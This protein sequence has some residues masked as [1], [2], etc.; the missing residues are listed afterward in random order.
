MS[1]EKEDRWREGSWGVLA[2][3]GIALGLVF[4]LL[5]L[6]AFPFRMGSMGDIRPMLLLILVY[7]WAVVE[8]MR[9]SYF[10]TFAMGLLLDLL[11]G[12]PL[13]MNG[14]TL[15]AAQW[16]AAAQQRFLVSQPFHVIWACF[17]LVAVAAGTLQWCISSLF[18][19]ALLPVLPVVAA[20]VLTVLVFPL[21]VPLL[22]WAYKGLSEQTPQR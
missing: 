19:V 22:V 4:I 15:V 12:L 21:M 13:G 10:A 3:Y 20:V 14:M 17:A 11:C 18:N 16:T 6:S 7:H 8:P 1:F 9:L 2:R 5:L